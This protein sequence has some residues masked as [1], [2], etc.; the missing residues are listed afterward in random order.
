MSSSGQFNTG[1]D[2][3]LDIVGARGPLR[4]S[5]ITGFDS[6][7]QYKSLESKGIDGIGRFDDLPDG[8]SGSFKL[9]RMDSAVD[10]FFAQKESDFYAGISNSTVTITETIQEI[11]G[12]ITQFRYVG[13]ALTLGDA[14]NKSSDSKIAMSI[15][16]KASRRLKV[17]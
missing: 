14:G 2:V 15:G 17:A 4:F 3:T 9:D 10:D 8:W 6:K 12:A 5:N 16:F 13:V 7:P 11:N 1:K